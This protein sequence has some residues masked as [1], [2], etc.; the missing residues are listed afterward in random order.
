[1]ALRG[2][3][4]EAGL[5]GDGGIVVVAGGGIVKALERDRADA[6]GFFIAVSCHRFPSG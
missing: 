1:M 2:L 3:F 4:D 6:G 5:V